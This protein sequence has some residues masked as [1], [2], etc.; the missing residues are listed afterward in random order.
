MNDEEF[1][2]VGLKPG[3]GGKGVKGLD[4]KEVPES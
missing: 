3:P 4:A 2:A 1:K